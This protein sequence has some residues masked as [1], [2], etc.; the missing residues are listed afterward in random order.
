MYLRTYV[1]VYV[2]MTGLLDEDARGR[3]I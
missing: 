3:H 1:C 2:C